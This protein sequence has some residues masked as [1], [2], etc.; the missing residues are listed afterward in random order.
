MLRALAL[1]NFIYLYSNK[2]Y[3]HMLYTYTYT[4]LTYCHKEMRGYKKIGNI[5]TYCIRKATYSQ[6][7]YIVFLQP[8][9]DGIIM[10]LKRK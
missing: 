5:C 3:A 9:N 2:G 1:Y 6:M 10:E 8:Y 7:K 4:F